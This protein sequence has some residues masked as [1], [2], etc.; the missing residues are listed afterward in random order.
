MSIDV[1][2]GLNWNMIQVWF[3]NFITAHL[4]GLQ[5]GSCTHH[6]VN[7]HIYENQVELAKEQIKREPFAAPRF[8]MLQSVNI[9]D[10]MD[11]INKD[12]FDEY[13]AIEDYQYHPPIKYPFT[14]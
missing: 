5:M 7:C 12:N 10:L 8:V 3:L 2:L 4:T 9:Y 11:N 13:F 14:V 6:L 1:P